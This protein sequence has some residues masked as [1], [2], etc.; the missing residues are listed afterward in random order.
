MLGDD[1]A[2]P[3]PRQRTLYHRGRLPQ[4]LDRAPRARA[5]HG[6]A[7]GGGGQRPGGAG[8]G[9]LAQSPRSPR[10]G[11]RTRRP[12]GRTAHVRHPQHEAA[13]G[14]RRP[15]R[16][17]D[18]GRGRG[19]LPEYRGRRLVAHRIRRGAPLWRR[20][21]R[22]GDWRFPARA[23]TAWRWPWTT[24]P[25]PPAPCWKAAAPSLTAQ[26]KDVLVVGG[27]DTGNDCVATCL[28]Q[29]CRSVAQLEM[30]PAP[31]KRRAKANPWPEWPRVLRTDYGQLEAIAARG[32]GPAPV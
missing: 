6:Q 12:P 2:T 31:P 27:G 3:Q 20:A 28:R 19:L 7:R 8:G 1:A 26:G 4:R 17:A 13:Q 14:D 32:R 5:P 25:R 21:A 30:L 18:E 29:G 11:R 23:Q 9:G 24:S 10:D 15:P 22:P 16:G